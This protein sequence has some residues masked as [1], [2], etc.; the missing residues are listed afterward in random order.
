MA[1]FNLFEIKEKIITRLKTIFDPEIPVNIYDLGLIYK[2]NLREENNYL[3]VD[4]DMTLTSPACPVADALLS[5]VKYVTEAVD[6]VD[7]CY[8]SLVF[9]PVWDMT[10]LSDEGREELVL[11]GMNF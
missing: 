1:N 2:I 5:Q 8:V 3:F 6:E 7:E 10:K 9:E 4:I 11:S